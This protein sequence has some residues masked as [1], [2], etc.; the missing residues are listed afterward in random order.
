MSLLIVYLSES[1]LP[2][3]L[4]KSTSK[5][6]RDALNASFG[7]T[8]TIRML[9]LHLSLQHLQQKQDE[10]V[11]DFLQRAKS[12]VDEM[13]TTSKPLEREISMSTPSVVSNLNIQ[14]IVLTLLGHSEP[15]TF[16]NFQGLLL[17][18]KSI[19][20][21]KKLQIFEASSQANFCYNQ[22]CLT[23]CHHPS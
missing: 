1:V 21:F 23:K 10:Q 16:T 2:L 8:S 7:S 13:G 22:L 14:D 12:I 9:Y 5:A 15:T 18:Y 6:I 20:A 17:S 19:K 4:D 3:I 11:I